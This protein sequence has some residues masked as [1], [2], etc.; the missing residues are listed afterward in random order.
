MHRRHEQ[1]EHCWCDQCKEERRAA[2][3][4]TKQKMDTEAM[5]GIDKAVCAT[6]HQYCQQ[7]GNCIDCGACAATGCGE[8]IV[9]SKTYCLAKD[10]RALQK[11]VERLT[12]SRGIVVAAN[13]EQFKV[14]QR[15][16]RQ[17]EQQGFTIAALHNDCAAYI[18]QRDLAMAQA[19]FFRGRAKLLEKDLMEYLGGS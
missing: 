18:G 12:K 11:E 1:W 15:Q 2:N 10:F 9:F 4:A 7:C 3:E 5:K 6:S 17:I 13:A 8:E 19:H 14:I 16:N